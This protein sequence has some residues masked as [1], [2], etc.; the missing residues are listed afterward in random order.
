MLI[1][2][3]NKDKGGI[4]SAI[5]RLR[6]KVRRTKQINKLREGKQYTKPSVKKRLQKQKAIY[7]QKIRTQEEK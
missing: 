3:V 1:I 5:K 7:I 2:K 4:E 6:K